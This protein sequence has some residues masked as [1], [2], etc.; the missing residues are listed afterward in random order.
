MT[1]SVEVL[2]PTPP[3]ASGTPDFCTP[4]RRAAL[5]PAASLHRCLVVTGPLSCLG[6][7]K[8]AAAERFHAWGVESISMPGSGAVQMLSTPHSR[9]RRRERRAALRAFG[10]ALSAPPT[11]RAPKKNGGRRRA[12]RRGAQRCRRRFAGICAGRLLPAG[13]CRP[14]FAGRLLP[15]GYSPRGQGATP[16]P[17]VVTTLFAPLL[18]CSRSECYS[19]RCCVV[20]AVKKRCMFILFAPA[21][22]CGPMPNVVVKQHIT[23]GQNSRSQVVTQVVKQRPSGQNSRSQVVK[24]R[25]SGQKQPI[26]SGQTASEW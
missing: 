2:C 11:R 8:T 23:S 3:T 9:R 19:R 6:V 24:R 16:M 18:R 5:L 12:C 15:A 14:A 7:N 26:A 20:P 25:P 17:L 21:G 10:S 1:R 13:F 4:S 22:A